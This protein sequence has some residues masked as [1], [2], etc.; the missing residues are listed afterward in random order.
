MAAIYLKKNVTIEKKKEVS[1]FPVSKWNG[2]QYSPS[3][4][5]FERGNPFFSAVH[6]AVWHVEVEREIGSVFTFS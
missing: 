3:L 4:K 1:N 2:M 6:G 5:N